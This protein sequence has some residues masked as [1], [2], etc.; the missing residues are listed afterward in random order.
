MKK[1]NFNMSNIRNNTLSDKFKGES[2]IDMNK[3]YMSFIQQY[4]KNNDHILDIGTGNGFVLKLLNEYFPNLNLHLYG[5]D[6]SK[7]MLQ[8]AYVADNIQYI[9]GDNYSTHFTDNCFDIITAKNVTRFSANELYRILKNDGVFVFREYGKAK[10]LL[11]LQPLFPTKV[12][13][14]RDPNFYIKKLQKSG[15]SIKLYE[16]YIIEN[17]FNNIEHLINITKSF[18]FIKDYSEEDEQKIRNLYRNT[19][20]IVLHSDPF[21]LIAQKEK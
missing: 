10:G 7:Y 8:K 14:S 16:N 3:L 9:L 2:T 21:I 18:S 4:I 6:N 5:L 13:R 19:K 15:F 20:N 1:Y 17:K 11:E 12:I